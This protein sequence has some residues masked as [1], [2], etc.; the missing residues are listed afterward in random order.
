MRKGRPYMNK[1]KKSS[2]SKSLTLGIAILSSAAIVSTGFAA[3]V[4][5]GGAEASVSGTI[6]ADTVIN[7]E[8]TIAF[9]SGVDQ[10]NL[11]KIFFGTP[12]TNPTGIAGN[13]LG[14]EGKEKENLSISTTFTVANVAED[15]KNTEDSI[16]NIID[17]E[18]A[19]NKTRFEETTT[20]GAET[21]YS[22]LAGK[23]Y[24]AD[25]PA[26]KLGGDGTSVGVHIT[27]ASKDDASKTATFNLKIVFGW[28]SYFGNDGPYVFYNNKD[29]NGFVSGTSGTTW[30][31]DAETKL[32]EISKMKANFKLTLVTK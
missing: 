3:W 5:S 23:N 2:K 32:D 31:Q 19:T 18:S 16:K 21:K 11:G 30:K 27:F 25:L 29:K 4:I 15:L 12:K 20:T 14:T 17:V 9:A 13:W 28:G 26:I 22:T 8:H 6:E 7:R 24:L 1:F 10:S